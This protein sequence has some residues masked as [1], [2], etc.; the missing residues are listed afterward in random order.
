MK[1][2]AIILLYIGF[3]VA[4]H[5]Q[6]DTIIDSVV[7]NI[8]KQLLVFPQEK[9][10]LQT[11][12]PYYIT[13]EKIFFRAF[14][15]DAFSNRQD[16]LSRYVYVELINPAD[17]VAQRLKIRPDSVGLFYGAISLPEDL[18]Q[19]NYIIRAY[20]QY[21][22]NQGENSFFSK[23]VKISDP[24]ILSVQTESDFQFTE[25]GKINASLRFMDAKSKQ[26]IT[27]QLVSLRLNQDP[28]FTKRPDKDGWV[29]VKLT[30]PLNAPTRVL[31]AEF[32]NN[33]NVFKQYIP[34]PYPEGDFDVSFYPEGGHLIVG[35]SSNVAFKALSST[36]TA[37]DIEGKIVDSQGSTVTEFKTIHDGMG[38]LYMNPL[39]DEHYQAIC[40]YGDRTFRFDLPQV[41]ENALAL[42]AMVRDNK[43]WVSV[44]KQESTSYPELYLLIHSRGLVVYAKAWDSSK[45]FIT[46]DK[47]VF[48]SGVSHILLLTK[49]LQIISER[50]V[51]LL[52]DDNG[53]ATFRTQKDSYHKRELVTSEI[54]IR[55]EKQN[56]LAGNFSIAVTND[57]EVITDT[58][59][60]ILS[61]ILLRSE[62]RGTIDNPEYY[63][64]RGNKEAER[65]ADLLM[66]THGWTRYAIPEVING[67]L[68]YPKIPFEMSQ[69]FSGIVKSGLIP[70]PVKD[71]KVSLISLSHGFFDM[72]ETDENGQY[73]FGNFEFP[74]STQYV[75]Q[76]LNSKG[77][78]KQMT[79]LYVDEDTFPE[80]HTTRNQ[81]VITEEKK[82]SIFMDYVAKADL[83]YTYENGTRI[84][85]LPEV[86]VRGFYKEK[87]KDQYKSAYYSDPDYSISSEEIEKHATIDV[88]NLLYGIPGVVVSGNS[89][90]IRGASGPPLIV[91]DDMAL[92]AEGD[93]GTIENLNMVSP[94]DIGKI[95]VLKTIGNT[96]MYGVRGANG[97]IVI[98][99]KRGEWHSAIPSFNI[100]QLIPL[101]YQ[102]PVDFYSPKYDTQ[103]SIHN[104]KPDLRTTIYWKPNVIAD[105]DGNAKLDFYTAD[106]PATYSVIIEGV[107]NDGRLIHYRGNS[108]ITVN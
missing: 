108:L 72:A 23:Q 59:S 64:Q 12:K 5:A 103:E 39:P 80:I 107:S 106:D 92:E 76:A 9:I 15:L 14:L 28:A 63:F 16:T 33:R 42:K 65:A 20:T 96:A 30:V 58:T 105:A 67:K 48:P 17:S 68:S 81:P 88:K 6:K 99:T 55:D 19:G 50:L 11:D 4:L 2:I 41:Q 97:V 21:M 84:V 77:K 40:H 7:N 13:G 38:E 62:L 44:N 100:K 90:R 34:I 61:G 82:D 51:F 93:Q 22:R 49:D 37:L 75:I 104:S 57:N 54:Q 29:R 3:T 91:I 74:D 70:K 83:Y 73:R 87:E 66:K 46:F 1:R 47:S 60:S 95:D 98:F 26:I 24:Q 86:Q 35:Q 101:G 56:P 32:T 85:H 18:P 27:S 43:L 25:D 94:Y 52:S 31:Y 53:T 89:I 102:M 8:A 71:F 36:G 78:G 79:D 10:Y 45:G 69:G